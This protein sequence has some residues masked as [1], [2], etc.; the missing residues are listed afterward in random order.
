MLSDA[1][2]ADGVFVTFAMADAEDEGEYEVRFSA[3]DKV[4]ELTTIAD[5]TKVTT[6]NSVADPWAATYTAAVGATAAT[7]TGKGTVFTTATGWEFVT[8]GT[9][10]V[11]NG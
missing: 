9:A 8:W 7:C 10:P 5:I 6:V 11:Y 1:A 4:C 3:D 2:E